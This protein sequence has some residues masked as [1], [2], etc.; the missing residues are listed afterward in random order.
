MHCLYN[1]VIVVVENKFQFNSK[2]NSIQ[3]VLLKNEVH[4][5]INICHYN[6]TSTTMCITDLPVVKQNMA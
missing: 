4:N 1:V 5:I 6:C 3:Y 2:F